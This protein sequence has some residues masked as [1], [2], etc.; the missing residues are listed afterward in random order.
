MADIKA[1]ILFVD[2]DNFLRK[3][4]QSELGERGYEVIL[5]ADGQEGLEKALAEHPNLILLD[6]TMPVMDGMEMLAKLREDAWGKQ[7]KVIVLTNLDFNIKASESFKLGVYEY[8]VKTNWN[9]G[10]IVGKVK[11]KLGEFGKSHI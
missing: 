5:A 1:K 9:L 11:E 4:Y 8:L 10:D 2:D 6:I 7:A 3:V